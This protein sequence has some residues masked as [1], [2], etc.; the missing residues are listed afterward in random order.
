VDLIAPLCK[1]WHP[2]HYSVAIQATP[3]ITKFILSAVPDECDASTTRRA[4]PLHLAVSNR[5]IQNTIVLLKAGA[6]VNFANANGNTPLHIAMVHEDTTVAEV[7]LSFGA[8]LR[9][10][11]AKGQRPEDVAEQRGD[12]VTV[13]LF[14]SVAAGK[15]VI[16]QKEKILT[17]F[18]PKT[19]GAEAGRR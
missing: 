9:A 17:D 15:R 12:I 16:T 19:R 4:A 3:E 1:G 11:N 13:E 2:I 6:A 5:D 14:R 10:K 8:D 18:R 7:L